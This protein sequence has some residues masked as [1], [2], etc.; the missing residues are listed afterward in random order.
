MS[1]LGNNEIMSENINFYM[2]LLGK[3]RNKVCDDL[4]FKYSTFS[5]WANGNKY[6]RIDSIKKYRPTIKVRRFVFGVSLFLRTPM[7]L[8]LF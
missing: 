1:N 4:G 7:L 8:K 2:S 6:P 5:D 3:D